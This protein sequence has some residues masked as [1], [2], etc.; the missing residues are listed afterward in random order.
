MSKDCT[1]VVIELEQLSESIEVTLKGKMHSV[2]QMTQSQWMQGCPEG[3][4]QSVSIQPF[5][6]ISTDLMQHLFSISSASISKLLNWTQC[7]RL[8][9]RLL[10]CRRKVYWSCLVP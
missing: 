5:S 3:S 2:E 8:V 1:K 6:D 10:R 9:K 4:E 7:V